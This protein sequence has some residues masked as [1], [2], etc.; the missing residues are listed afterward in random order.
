MKKLGRRKGKSILE[1]E[2]EEIKKRD[3]WKGGTLHSSS[4]SQ[5]Q[6]GQIHD[7]IAT[8][9]DWVS[10]FGQKSNST[11]ILNFKKKNGQVDRNLFFGFCVQLYTAITLATKDKP[12]SGYMKTAELALVS[13][14]AFGWLDDSKN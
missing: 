2:L 5:W 11:P 12:E 4:I 14:Y 1:T 10:T 7:G 9:A 13:A 6:S 8:C 3:F